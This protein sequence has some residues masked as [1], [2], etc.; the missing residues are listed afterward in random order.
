MFDKVQ[1]N[2]VELRLPCGQCHGCRLARAKAWAVR[3]MHEAQCHKAN[4]FL[5]LT[6]DKENLP[7]DWSVNVRDFQLFMKRLRK[8]KK[9]Q[10]LRYFMCAEYGGDRLRPHYHCCLFGED[11]I[12]DRRYLRKSESGFPIYVSAELEKCWQKGFANIGELEYDSALYVSKYIMKK[13]TGEQAEDHYLRVDKDNGECF[14]VRPE[15]V[16]MS[17]RPGIGA[18]WFDKFGRREIYESDDQVVIEGRKVRPPRY[19]DD[20]LGDEEL[21][22]QV[23]VKRVREALR[24]TD[25]LTPDRLKARE[26]V[27]ELR[28]RCLERNRC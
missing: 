28:E 2:G 23:K 3:I 26:R 18:E 9:G 10:P 24:H 16:T 20:R 6:Y 17:R 13:K 27:A 19:Y 15:F 4:S 14:Q 22:D 7:R 25:D 21:L 8:L 1:G 5:T 11:F 12:F